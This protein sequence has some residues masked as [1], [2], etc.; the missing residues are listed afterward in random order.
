MIIT[1]KSATKYKRGRSA[2]RRGTLN[3]LRLREHHNYALATVNNGYIESRIVVETLASLRDN[4]KFVIDEI[5]VPSKAGET[6]PIT[7]SPHRIK[8]L[9]QNMITRREYEKSIVLLISIA[10]DYLLSSARLILRAYPER[11]SISVK[12]NEGKVTVEFKEL[13]EQGMD[14]IVEAN[15]GR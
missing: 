1:T 15:T 9:I 7:P 6:T 4:P 10:E 13:I 2:K 12:G 14:Q 3:Y 8:D 11:I 5:T